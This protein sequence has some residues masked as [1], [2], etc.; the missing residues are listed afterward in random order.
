MIVYSVC[1]QMINQ[2]NECNG[3]FIT[4]LMFG[5]EEGWS[6]G[7]RGEGVYFSR[8]IVAAAIKAAPWTRARSSKSKRGL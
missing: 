4:R 5:Q 1:N 3:D 6:E 7:N 8:S 2:I